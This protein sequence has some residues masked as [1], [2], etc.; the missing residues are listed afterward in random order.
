VDLPQLRRLR[1]LRPVRQYKYTA[2]TTTL[3][4]LNYGYD[5]GS[6]RVYRQDA[7]R[8]MGSDPFSSLTPFLR[9]TVL[10]D[11]SKS[12]RA[13]KQMTFRVEMWAKKVGQNNFA[14][15]DEW[16]FKFRLYQWTEKDKGK[17]VQRF[18]LEEWQ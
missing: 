2:D 9:P 15:I 12:T 17:D 16:E 7:S 1:P 4:E 18:K 10:A 3:A 5:A 8:V 13:E 14:K 6:N 11:G